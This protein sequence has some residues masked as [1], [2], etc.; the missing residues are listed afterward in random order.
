MIDVSA[1]T[2]AAIGIKNDGIGEVRMEV[3]ADEE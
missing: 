3:L 2:A 1:G